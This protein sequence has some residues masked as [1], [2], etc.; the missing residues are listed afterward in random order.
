MDKLSLYEILS[1]VIPGLV[2]LK[3]IELYNEKVFDGLPL[4][5]SDSKISESIMLFGISLFIGIF[6]HIAT[7]RLLK[8]QK[9]KWYKKLLFKSPQNICDKN[10]FIKPVIPFLNSEYNNLRKHEMPAGKENELETNLFDFAY[11]YLEVNDKIT[12]AKNFQSLYFLFRNLFTI[13]LLLL[14]VSIFFYIY[15]LIQD[16]FSTRINY[17]LGIMLANIA[18]A[19]F[20]FLKFFYLMKIHIQITLLK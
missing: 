18:I 10:D 20:L 5:E 19:L 16:F 13:C 12:P 14:P 3:I 4:I 7:F 6:I 2:L 9:L 1:F 15:S 17:A 8:T 11:L